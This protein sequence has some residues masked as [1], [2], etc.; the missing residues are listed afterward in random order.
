MAE[1]P[2]LITPCPHCGEAVTEAQSVCANCGAER[3]AIWP[4]AVTAAAPQIEPTRT[5]LLT[6]KVW[7]DEAAGLGLCWLLMTGLGKASSFLVVAYLQYVVRVPLSQEV[8]PYYVPWL[9]LGAF[10]L[11]VFGGI[12]LGLR[13]GFPR[14][15]RSFGQNALFGVGIALAIVLWLALFP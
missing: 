15:G 4:P 6:G 10:A 7:L 12:Y 8:L 13:R 5:R 3:E 2:A 11:A 14:M 1:E 9:G